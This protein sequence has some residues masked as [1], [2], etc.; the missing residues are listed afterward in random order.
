M[1]KL[2]IKEQKKIVGGY[3]E[4]CTGVQAEAEDLISH[5]ATG[6]QWDRWAEKYAKFC[7]D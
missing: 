4:S 2:S 3:E 6:A 7:E 5:G 1:K